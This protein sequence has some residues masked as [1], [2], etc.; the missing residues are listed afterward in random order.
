M[1]LKDILKKINI[2]H[3]IIII[4][5]YHI[6]APLF[7]IINEPSIGPNALEIL[8]FLEKDEIKKI[9]PT[10]M[11]D[12]FYN[13][14][15]TL[16]NGQIK[17]YPWVNIFQYNKICDKI[18]GKEKNSI[19]S[20]VEPKQDHLANFK[21]S[22][23]AGFSMCLSI[24]FFYYL[25]TSLKFT[26]SPLLE[27]FMDKQGQDKSPNNEF[28]D[29]LRSRKP[30][31]TF[32]DIAG[33]QE[34]KE[35]MKELVDFLKNSQKYVEMGARIPKGILLSGL[36]GT[37]KT[38]LAKALA[39]EAGVLF[40]A[41]SGSEFVEMYA[42]LAAL[43]MRNLFKKAKKNA[44]CIIFIDEIETIA[45]KRGSHSNFAEQEQA[46][47]QLLVELD[48]YNQNTGVIVIAAT[49]KPRMLD[50]ALLRPGRFDRIFRVNL[51]NLKDR[52]AILKLHASNKKLGPDV[53][54]EE[55]AKQTP[56]M[57][58]A[59]LEGILNEAALLAIR[60]KSSFIDKK[61]LSEATDRILMGPAKKSRK[62][63]EKEKKMVA[64]HEAGHAVIGLRLPDSKKVQKVTIIPRGDAGGYNL[65]LD[66]EELF[67]SSKKKLL[68][69]ITILLGG[70]ASEELFLD[71]ISNGAVG[72]FERATEIARMM[73]TK[74]GMSKIGL[75]QFV[76][77]EK[78]F[79]KNFSDPK[80]LE[81]DQAIQEIIS[82]CYEMAKKII[83]ANKE[84]L[85]KISEYLI[86]LETLSKK[87]ID[88]ID[89]TG[90]LFWFEEE[91]KQNVSSEY[92]DLNIIDQKEDQKTVQNENDKN[93]I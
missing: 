64:Y 6:M 83:S 5:L 93:K 29:F 17:K 68:A 16:L 48:G 10:L 21:D 18:E 78:Y 56:G 89:K 3:I 81:I 72:D 36:P 43:R 66:E 82:N 42:G 20:G 30:D 70:R 79:H 39:G 24:L 73:V 37:G 74:F 9:E 54:L 91:K 84:L 35:E 8:D 2:W 19:I 57:S 76:E 55:L 12:S 28:L 26:I 69:E 63:S 22:F 32:K 65:I 77:D 53:N 92:I 15:I 47:N 88:E 86:D 33:A 60:K 46:L 41:V 80:A 90:M 38:L 44:P 49:N 14:K 31:I 62:Y 71:D 40:I 7:Y 67:F 23:L 61:I 13:I 1:E 87:D 11:S 58:G 50:S 4:M 51:P 85:S 52:E 34:E 25:Y 75:T 27:Q 59:Q 45:R